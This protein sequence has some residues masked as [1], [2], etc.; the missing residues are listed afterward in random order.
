MSYDS[1]IE[2]EPA[3]SQIMYR[4]EWFSVRAGPFEIITAVEGAAPNDLLIF[5]EADTGRTLW[6]RAGE[7]D[8]VITG[9]VNASEAVEDD[10]KWL[11]E[12]T[13]IEPGC[14]ECERRG[15]RHL[16]PRGRGD[17]Y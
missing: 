17:R 16:M 11:E 12:A 10:L 9:E 14:R 3:H 13:L 5:G 15:H 7:V 6:L 2:R 8:G 1:R 4:G